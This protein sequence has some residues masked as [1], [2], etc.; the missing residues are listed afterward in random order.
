MDSSSTS[1]YSRMAGADMIISKNI[2][3]GRSRLQGTTVIER[4]A[5]ALASNAG[6]FDETELAEQT[7]RSPAENCRLQ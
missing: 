5:T 6:F 1:K 4:Y 2:E 3:N 7:G